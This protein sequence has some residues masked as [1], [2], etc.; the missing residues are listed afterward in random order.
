M[1]GR[2]KMFNLMP[3]QVIF[4]ISRMTP[5]ETTHDEPVM[6]ATTIQQTGEATARPATEP[7][8][9]AFPAMGACCRPVAA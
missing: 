2:Y 5:L 9:T 1:K 8:A 3:W 6:P 4:E 7:T